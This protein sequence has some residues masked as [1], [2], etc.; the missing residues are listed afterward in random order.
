MPVHQP[1]FAHIV[2]ENHEV[3]PPNNDV[4]PYETIITIQ[5]DPFH[6]LYLHLNERA[7]TIT[8]SAK[9]NLEMV[10]GTCGKPNSTSAHLNMWNR[11][12]DMVTSW[13]LNSISPEIGSSVVYLS[14]AQAIWDDLHSRFT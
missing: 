5:L 14:T 10:N 7:M 12:N 9:I 3:V 8:L 13:L 4:D 2:I 1:S 11:C 6:P